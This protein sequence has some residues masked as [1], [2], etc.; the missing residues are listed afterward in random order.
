[1]H[2]EGG[3]SVALLHDSGTLVSIFPRRMRRQASRT[4]VRDLP[5][6]DAASNRPSLLRGP[7]GEAWRSPA[8]PGFAMT[9]VVTKLDDV[10]AA[11]TSRCLGG[12][13]RFLTLMMVRCWSG[14][15]HVA[16][17]N[18]ARAQLRESDQRYALAVAGSNEGLWDWTGDGDL[19]FSERAQ[20]LCGMPPG[21]PLRPRRAWHA[22]LL[23]HPRT[24][25]V[26]RRNEG[27]S[28]GRRRIS[29]SSSCSRA[30]RGRSDATRGE[31]D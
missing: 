20:E 6:R 15:A 30:P 16:R 17:V 18:A 22:L 4:G 25:A 23:V 2:L 10:L 5:R 11:C 28:R 9:V 27:A 14:A 19:F 24:C 13:D 3:T 8:V 29:I 7:G 26:A 21:P 1:V 31:P 12:A